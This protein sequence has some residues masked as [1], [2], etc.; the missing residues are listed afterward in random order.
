[1]MKFVYVLD[2]NKRLIDLCRIKSDR[3]AKLKELIYFEE[4][5]GLILAVDL[6][7]AKIENLINDLLSERN[8]NA[9]DIPEYGN[10]FLESEIFEVRKFKGVD[11]KLCNSGFDNTIIF[12]I[13]IY[14]NI[15]NNGV[16]HYLLFINNHKEFNPAGATR[17]P[18]S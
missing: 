5:E 1:M 18:R 8:L 2:S 4:S 10:R 15:L 13:N 6:D 14:N 12:L 17:L 3:Y 7:F 16:R 9:L 11:L